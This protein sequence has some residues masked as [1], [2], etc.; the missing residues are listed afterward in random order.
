MRQVV[1][2]TR[3]KV[4]LEIRLGMEPGVKKAETFE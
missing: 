4:E 3:D 1:C 2:T